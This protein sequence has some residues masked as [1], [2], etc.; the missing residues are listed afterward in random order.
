MPET[1]EPFHRIE[2][3]KKI[4]VIPGKE[5]EKEKERTIE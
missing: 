2:K 5:R 3:K 1:Q 4:Y